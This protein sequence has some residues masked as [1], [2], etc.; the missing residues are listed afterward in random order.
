MNKRKVNEDE[1]LD[2]LPFLKGIEQAGIRELQR[3]GIFSLIP[4]NQFITMEGDSCQFFS[5][6]LSGKIKVYK[7]AENGREITLYRLEK[8]QSCILTA[9]CILSNKNFPAI[10]F[11]EEAVGV[12]SIPSPLFLE[13]VG[14][15]DFWRNY[16]FN[17]LS[18]RLSAIIS[19]VEE[20]AFRNVD[21]RLA[22][23]LINITN[24]N[25]DEIK[26]THQ[27]IA[28]DIGTSREVVSRLLKDF[29][30]EGILILSRGSIKIIDYPSLNAKLKKV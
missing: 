17:L 8:G 1:I 24:V 7:T 12:I 13:W 30:E 21:I 3:F 16:V 4:K 28:G 29:E 15:Y 25:K 9:S 20:I 19:V 6:V 5:F 23:H 26:T 10:S 27:L 2:A 22:Q 11:S 14:K 18:E